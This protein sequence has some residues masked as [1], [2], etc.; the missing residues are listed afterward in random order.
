VNLE[1]IIALISKSCVKSKYFFT[2]DEKTKDLKEEESTQNIQKTQK[3]NIRTES[4]PKYVNP[5]TDCTPEEVDKYISLF[6]EYF[7]IFAWIYDDIK[8]L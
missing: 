5:R 8:V 4:S 2:R 7:D 1:E 6:K 3:I